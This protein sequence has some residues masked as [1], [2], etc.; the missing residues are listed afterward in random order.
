MTNAPGGA[1]Y[2][3]TEL[4]DRADWG[5]VKG[6][7]KKPSTVQA[8]LQRILRRWVPVCHYDGAKSR[9]SAAG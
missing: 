1:A 2:P 7:L 8:S 3:T 9:A 5:P 6:P 4:Q